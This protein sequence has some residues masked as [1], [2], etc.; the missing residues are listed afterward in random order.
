MIISV[1]LYRA[2]VYILFRYENDSPDT[3]TI[4]QTSESS[5]MEFCN[6]SSHSLSTLSPFSSDQAGQPST[7]KNE[8]LKV[9]PCN[10]MPIDSNAMEILCMP[11][12]DSPRQHP[13]HLPG[14][15]ESIPDSLRWTDVCLDEEK[16]KERIRV[17]KENRRKRYKDA[18]KKNSTIS[19]S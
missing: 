18:L 17:Y 15:P 4:D 16:E 2:F 3:I 7:S 1:R 6:G 9:V 5:A 19:T 11:P 8:M 14:C 12:E 13:N 10:S